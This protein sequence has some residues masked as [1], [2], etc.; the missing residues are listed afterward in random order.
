MAEKYKNTHNI[1]SSIPEH[2]QEE[3]FKDLLKTDHIRIERILSQGQASPAK[4]WYDQAEHEWVMVLEGSGVL[5]LKTAENHTGQRRL[6]PHPGPC[7]APGRLDRSG[8][9]NG[10]AGGVLQ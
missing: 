10:V 2:I 6:S 3:I 8:P 5:L 7:A 9:G 1:F 4:G